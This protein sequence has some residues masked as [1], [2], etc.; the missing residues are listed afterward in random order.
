V[1]RGIPDTMPSSVSRPIL[2]AFCLLTSRFSL[3]AAQAWN[4]PAAVELV[5]RGVERRSA[6]QADPGLR[7]YRASAHGLV[8]FL[9]Q[10]G[11]GLGGPPR[12]VKADE[13]N[14]E[15]Y[16]QGPNRSKQVILGWRDTTFLPTDIKY[17][18]DHLGIVTNNFGD[19]IRIGEGDEVRDAVHPLSPA[20]LADYDFALGDSLAI[21]G[22]QG[23]VRVQEVLV[24]PHD[25][26][27]PLVVGT[28]YLDAASADLVRFRFSFTPA[29]YLE[30]NLEDISVVLENSLREGR[31][32]LP[33]RQEIE[34][35]RRTTWLDFPARGIIRGRWEI[36]DYDLGVAVPP[37]VLAGPAIGGLLDALPDDSTWQRPLRDAVAGEAVPAGRQDMEAVRS[38]VERLAG[39]RVLSG[40]PR[41]RLSV[42]ALSDLAHV[43]RVQGLTL[44]LGGTVRI[45]SSRVWL[46]P[47]AAFGTSDHRLTGGLALRT[48][49]GPVEIELS[50]RRW[51]RDLSDVPVVSPLLNSFLS[52][53]NGDDYGDYVLLD[54]AGAGVRYTL[55]ART[56][57]GLD[58]DVERSRSLDVAATPARG[59][60]R[61][62]PALGA[63]TY[64]VARLRLERASGAAP[65]P[66]IGGAVALEAG[67]GPTTYVRAS[68]DGTWLV[69][70]GGTAFAGRLNAGW[71]SDGLPAYRSFVLGGRGTLVG[72]PFRAFG[73]RSYALAELEWRLNVPGPAIPLGSFASTGHT[74]VLAPFM[75]AGWSGR[76]YPGLPWPATG[77]VRPVAGLAAE[78]FMRLIRVEAGVGLRNG[79]VGLTLDVHPDW[80]G[81]L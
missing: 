29:A 7:S 4:S 39:E 71:G 6:A 44:G 52:Q 81:V 79:D 46:E 67:D 13:L 48:G 22:P 64:R 76:P 34:I 18:R 17:H 65:G 8:F 40:L 25:Y 75:A 5:R 14:V 27:R 54:M 62:N 24:R 58:L 21:Q 11:K 20:G 72:E 70:A 74:M 16:W 30:S 47:A 33:Y 37:V 15:V 41:A 66:G 57:L 36:G 3:L 55:G 78:L 38:D 49:L 60:Y 50:G 61:P 45:G 35:R 31:Y 77:G 42:G 68:V 10:V 56:R 63:G 32:W 59:A 28:L 9:A 69:P 43:N 23:L 19:L 80:W 1:R 73:G 51:V 12:L 26:S 53:E 2:L